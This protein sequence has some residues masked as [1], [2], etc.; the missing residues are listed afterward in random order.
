MQRFQ[1]PKQNVAYTFQDQSKYTYI[2]QRKTI[3][4]SVI[5]Q[6]GNITMDNMTFKMTGTNFG[7]T[8]TV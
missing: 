7:T 6:K 4:K 8:S 3:E 5:Q 2:H 1:I